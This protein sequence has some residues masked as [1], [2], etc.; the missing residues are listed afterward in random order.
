[1][2]IVSILMLATTLSLSNLVVADNNEKKSNA[3]EFQDAKVSILKNVSTHMEVLSNFKTCV[4]TAKAGPEL[5][6]CKKKRKS[7]LKALK[8]EIKGKRSQ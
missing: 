4:E 6:A 1:M 8:K 2:K 5:T 3:D 7:A